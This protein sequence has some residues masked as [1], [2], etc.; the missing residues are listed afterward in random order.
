MGRFGNSPSEEGRYLQRES[1]FYENQQRVAQQ[2]AFNEKTRRENNKEQCP[3]CQSL[4]KFKISFSWDTQSYKVE[5]LFCCNP[6][7][8]I[9][10]V[11]NEN[12][13]NYSPNSTVNSPTT[14]TTPNKKSA[15]ERIADLEKELADL[16]QQK[17]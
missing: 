10:N 16:K 17:N 3:F 13:W 7:P 11:E 5:Q 1:K 9:R 15:E 4:L 14:P 2:E 12:L 6:P 8:N